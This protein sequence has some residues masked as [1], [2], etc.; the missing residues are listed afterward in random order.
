MSATDHLTPESAAAIAREAHQ[1]WR[2]VRHSLSVPYQAKRAAARREMVEG[3]LEL[4][5]RILGDLLRRILRD[6]PPAIG[7]QLAA[8]IGWAAADREMILED[9]FSLES[10]DQK[11]RVAGPR[12]PK[13][14]PPVCAPGAEEDELDA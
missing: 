8:A 4:H 1:A 13:A 3:R 5:G 7:E 10:G 9:L 12:G 11:T 14:S 6:C 2:Q